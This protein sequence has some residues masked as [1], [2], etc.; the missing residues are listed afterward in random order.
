MY[1]FAYMQS[2]KIQ[3]PE[4]FS[5]ST[6]ITVR[7]TDINYGGHV[8]NDAILGIIH[9][10]RLQFLQH[11]GY[12]SELDVAGTSL[13]MADSAIVYKGESFY[14]DIIKAEIAADD[15]S[16]YG[17][18]LVYRLSN[19]QTGKEIAHAKTGMVCFNYQT[20]KIAALPAAL[21]EQFETKAG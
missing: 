10:A 1:T 16:K 7:I 9:E 11:L 15:I 8:G 20:R 5:F 12:Q 13:I 2:V 21:R 3:F 6:E 17:F 14:G 18:D 4:V 19:L